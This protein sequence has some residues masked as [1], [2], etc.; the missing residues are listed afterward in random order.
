MTL[1]INKSFSLFLQ[2][3]ASSDELEI[4]LDSWLDPPPL[5]V[6]HRCKTDLPRNMCCQCQFETLHRF[7]PLLVTSTLKSVNHKLPHES[8]AIQSCP[9]KTNKVWERKKTYRFQFRMVVFVWLNIFGLKMVFNLWI[10]F[11]KSLNFQVQNLSGAHLHLSTLST[12]FIYAAVEPPHLMAL[13]PDLQS[14]IS[15]NLY[16]ISTE[17][18]YLEFAK[19]KSTS[20]N[21]A[22]SW[23]T[24]T[25]SK[26]RVISPIIC[27]A[28]PFCLRY[29]VEATGK[30]ISDNKNKYLL[31]LLT[32]PGFLIRPNSDF[33][34]SA[35]RIS[36]RLPVYLSLLCEQ[37]WFLD[38]E[39]LPFIN[40][41]II[42]KQLSVHNSSRRLWETL[43]CL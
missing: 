5:S 26:S 2:P 32:A 28:W 17:I 37:F 6:N 39:T 38:S 21:V 40:V 23:E 1:P 9:A 11:I 30:Y 41:G 33:C 34:R 36:A 19:Y 18:Q 31:H 12:S 15:R 43:H 27:C 24:L 22:S 20:K 29:A 13:H 7:L 42:K 35:K 10:S 16:C 25:P 3:A 14:S 8:F 4:N